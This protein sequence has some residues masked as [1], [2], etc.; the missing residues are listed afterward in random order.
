MTNYRLG[1]AE[2][3][4][5]IT[6]PLVRLLFYHASLKKVKEE[7]GKNCLV[8]FRFEFLDYFWRMLVNL[9]SFSIQM[10]KTFATVPNCLRL[11]QSYLSLYPP[12]ILSSPFCYFLFPL[13]AQQNQNVF[14][15]TSVKKTQ[16]ASS[17]HSRT[18]PRLQAGENSFGKKNPPQ[19][20]NCFRGGHKAYQNAINSFLVI[21]THFTQL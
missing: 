16:A 14:Y 20:H 12:R 21:K 13:F 10:A 5:R 1:S 11:S 15:K 8:N 4:Q 9:V 18:P 2:S 7:R 17:R 3:L 6:I 19:K